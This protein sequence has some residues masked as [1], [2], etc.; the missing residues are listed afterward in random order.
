MWW[1]GTFFAW[2]SIFK[3][4]MDDFGRVDDKPAFAM[5]VATAAFVSVGAF[6]VLFMNNRFIYI[7]I[8]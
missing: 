4:Y 5:L 6:F 3:W 2:W 7:Y 8:L 1:I